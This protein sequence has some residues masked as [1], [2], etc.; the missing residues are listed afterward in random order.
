MGSRSLIMHVASSALSKSNS[1]SIRHLLEDQRELSQF[2]KV[3]EDIG[4]L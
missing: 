3:C 4:S 1:S 2:V